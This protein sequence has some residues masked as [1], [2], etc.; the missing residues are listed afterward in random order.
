MF[1]FH[2]VRNRS[3]LDRCPMLCFFNNRQVFL[4]SCLSGFCDH[5]GHWLPATDKSAHSLMGHLNDVAADVALVNLILLCHSVTS[6]SF[7]KLLD[8]SRPSI[9]ITLIH[10]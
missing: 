8:R 10:I 4:V 5:L 3:D 6:L 9:F 7:H 1:F 2:W